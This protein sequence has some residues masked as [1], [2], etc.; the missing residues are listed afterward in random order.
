MLL[1][2]NINAITTDLGAPSLVLRRVSFKLKLTCLVLI[3]LTA[4]GCNMFRRISEIGTE[5]KMTPIADPTRRPEYKP[6]SMPMPTPQTAARVPGSLWRPGARAFFRDQRANKVGDIVTVTVTIN[7]NAQL[8]N[9]TTRQRNGGETLGVPNVLGFE[10]EVSDWLP[11]GFNAATAVNLN[12]TSTSGATT[13]AN[14]SEAI[15]LRVAAVVTQLLPNGNLVL[16]GRQETRVNFD[17]RELVVGG[18][19]RRQD[20][21]SNNEVPYDRIA[22]ARIAYGGRGMMTDM[23]QP[24]YGQ[25]VLDIILP[26]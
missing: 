12:S 25:Q 9:N 16:H 22:E 5:P 19:V 23:Q 20:I 4:N 11:R 1:S 8:R 21:N 2:A 24:R 10:T 15:N 13:T 6:I 7:D 3:L 18:V 26:F 17:V 14:R